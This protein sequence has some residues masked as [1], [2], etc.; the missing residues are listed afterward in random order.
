MQHTLVAVFDNR[1]DAQKAMDE[2]LGS[3]F[4]QP[5]VRLSEGEPAAA[6][7]P[8]SSAT[9]PSTRDDGSAVS[10]IKNFFSDLFGSDRGDQAQVYSEAVN[11]GHYVLTVVA[12]DQP[13]VERAADLVERF[14]P[15]DIDE[16]AEQWRSAGWTG[17]APSMMGGA[18]A[19][20]QAQ[21]MAQQQT[22]Q[23]GSVQGSSVQG[24][25]QREQPATTAIPVI[26]EEL[27]VGKREVQRGGVRV[28]S[29]MVETPVSE[30]VGLREEHVSVERRPVDQPI[31]PADVAAF[32]ETTL[33]VRET[34]EQA[35]VEKTARVVEEVIVGKDVTQREEQISDTVRHTEVEVEPLSASAAGTASMDDDSY[36]R[37]HWNTNYA[38]SGGAYDEYA[39]AYR[40]GSSMAG[41]DAYRGKPWNDV[42][43]RL[44]T[45]WEAKNPGSAW[46]KFKAAIRHGWDRIT[47]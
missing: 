32:K 46:E 18:G 11:R 30:T 35:V 1:A 44:R 12:P 23:G 22:V 2:L 28:F 31:S 24:S 38:A 43:P 29:R 36:F 39:P 26:E 9:T 33:E 17:Q 10:G 37:S 4:K 40:Y 34:A 5:E 19:Q 20:Q 41:S 3:G 21:P 42:E 25:Q 7:S 45:D 27:R 13:E 14:G 47:S 16:R 6:G 15:V 8:S